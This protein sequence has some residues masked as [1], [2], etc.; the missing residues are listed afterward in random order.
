MKTT[1]PE[2]GSRMT[3]LQ[4]DLEDILDEFNVTELAFE[5]EQRRLVTYLHN[6][7][8]PPAFKSVITTRLSLQENRRY[9]KE[10][11]PFCTW[12]MALLKEY[13]TWERASLTYGPPSV[14][15]A[16]GGN[17]S[18]GSGGGRSGRSSGG[19]NPSGHGGGRDTTRTG[20]LGGAGGSS[21][22]GGTGGRSGRGGRGTSSTDGAAPTNNAPSHASSSVAA[23]TPGPCLKCGSTTH[24]VRECTQL[25]SP[26]EA[27]QLLKEMRERRRSSQGMRKIALPSSPPG[28]DQGT[29]QA[30][31]DGVSVKALLLD[32]GADASVA[33]CSWSVGRAG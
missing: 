12:V 18:R 29:V 23:R 14:G 9:K 1:L 32:S 7:M 22:T 5:H 15:R 27:T 26:A 16:T 3:M 28:P 11:V 19:S 20:G 30:S 10:V 6:A 31:V 33:R 8:A 24:Q 25:S 21:G 13:M 2:P 17:N 4:S